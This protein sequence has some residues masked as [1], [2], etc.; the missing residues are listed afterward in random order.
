M[1]DWINWA[2]ANSLVWDDSL[3]RDLTINGGLT[4]VS[5]SKAFTP[6]VMTAVQASAITP[7]EGMQVHVTTTNGTFTAVGPWSYT[8]GAWVIMI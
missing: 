6:P 1:V 5:T 4:I 2:I 7:A 3:I 8:N